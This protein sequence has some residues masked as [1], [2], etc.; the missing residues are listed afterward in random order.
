MSCAN[1]KSG[2]Y[3]LQDNQK[4]FL[5]QH[6]HFFTAVK[7]VLEF[8]FRI[9]RHG[10]FRCYH[11]NYMAFKLSDLEI[12]IKNVHGYTRYFC[13][14]CSYTTTNELNMNNHRSLAHL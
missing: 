14:D 10:N 9:T 13:Q 8:H 12:H 4:M 3:N 6:C 1:K 7:R 2:K 5:C 11:C